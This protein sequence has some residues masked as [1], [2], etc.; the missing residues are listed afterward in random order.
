[1]IWPRLPLDKLPKTSLG[2]PK[3]DSS[4]DF[5]F[6][7]LAERVFSRPFHDIADALHRG[8]AV[9]ARDVCNGE[10]GLASGARILTNRSRWS[11]SAARQDH[12]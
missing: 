11:R 3:S 6:R 7:F 4:N 1:M 5:D 2:P 9:R 12:K 10:Q 8:V